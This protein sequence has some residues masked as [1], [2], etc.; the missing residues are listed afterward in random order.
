MRFLRCSFWWRSNVFSFSGTAQGSGLLSHS[1]EKG[2][3][4]GVSGF[5]I[6]NEPPK[7]GQSKF[8]ITE[9]AA[10]FVFYEGDEAAPPDFV[11]IL[12]AVFDLDEE[13]VFKSLEKKMDDGLLILFCGG[14]VVAEVDIHAP[15]ERTEYV[16]K[17]LAEV[18]GN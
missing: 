11:A 2:V 1:W 6:H 9:D 10:F 16:E 14:I 5:D 3:A 17:R 15:L 18:V 4:D 12:G 8:L 7:D 13:E